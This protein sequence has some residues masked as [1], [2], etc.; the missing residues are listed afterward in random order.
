MTVSFHTT[1]LDL[2]STPLGLLGPNTAVRHRCTLCS[3]TV[4]TTELVDHA[5]AHGRPPSSAEGGAID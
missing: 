5:R 3:A 4:A 2:A 1:V